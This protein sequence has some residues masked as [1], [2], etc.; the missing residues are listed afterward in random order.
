MRRAGY[1]VR[2]LPVEGMSW[3]DAMLTEFSRRLLRWCQGNM[4]YWQ[5]LSL[6]GLK[7]VSRFQL[8]FAIW[9]Y[10]GRRPGWR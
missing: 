2:V 1:E 8:L 5:L 4:Q 3:E 7:P 10:L 6:P 9:M